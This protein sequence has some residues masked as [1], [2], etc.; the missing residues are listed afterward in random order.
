MVKPVEQPLLALKP[1]S[2]CALVLIWCL[3]MRE[4]GAKAKSE[5]DIQVISE[6]IAEGQITETLRFVTSL[7]DVSLEVR[8]KEAGKPL[9]LKRYE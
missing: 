5:K 2:N 1:I 8:R 6:S 7:K 3:T 9:Y 4:G